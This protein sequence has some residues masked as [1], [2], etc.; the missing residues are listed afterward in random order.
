MRL[1]N[2]MHLRLRWQRSVSFDTR[3]REAKTMCFIELINHRLTDDLAITLSSNMD[4][5][6]QITR[7][8]VRIDIKLYTSV[9]GAW[10][11]GTNKNDFFSEQLFLES[12]I[13]LLIHESNEKASTVHLNKLAFCKKMIG[14]R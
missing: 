5:R 1:C 10:R 12:I 13:F 9:T 3:V 8:N 14:L 4:V 2:F 6:G 11:D 7:G